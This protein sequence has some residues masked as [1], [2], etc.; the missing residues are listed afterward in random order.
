MVEIALLC[1]AYILGLLLPSPG[2]TLLLC[3]GLLVVALLRSPYCRSLPLPLSWRYSPTWGWWVLAALV[4]SMAAL[5]FFVRLPTPSLQDVSRL[6]PASATSVPV[7]ITGKIEQRPALTRRG[8][9]QVWLQAQQATLEQTP[10]QTV[11]GHLYVTLPR[12][13]AKQLYPNQIVRILGQLYRPQ[14]STRPHGFD[15]EAFLAREGVF[16][17]L[18]GTQVR[19]IAPGS[20]WGGW[21][22][23][24]RIVAAL[25]QGA[26]KRTGALLSALVLG[27]DAADIAYDLKDSF[28]QSGLAHALAA[29]GFQVSLILSA[30]LALTQSFSPSKQVAIGFGALLGYGLLSGAEP[31][32]VRAILMG[33]ASLMAL[34]LKRQIRPVLLLLAIATLM[35]LWNPLWI[36]D[37]GFLLSMLATLGL[38]VTVPPLMGYLEWLPPTIASLVAVPL[39]ANLWTLPLQLYVFGVLP[40]YSLIA[41][42]LT[43]GLLS[44][45]TIGGF[46]ASC[47]ALIWPT[48]GSGFAWLLQ[49]PTQLLMGIVSSIAQLPGHALAIGT[50]SLWQLLTLYGCLGV[51]WI[52]GRRQW[53]LMTAVGL[54]MIL[55]PLW[56]VQTQRFL[57]TVFDRTQVPQMVIAH[58]KGTV[59]LNSGNPNAVTQSL[60]PF[61]HQEGINRIDW[62]I[63][64][65]SDASRQSGW[66]AL[67]RRMP[68]TTLS[69]CIPQATEIA[70][71][72]DPRP[73]REV[74]LNRQDR[75]SLGPL[76]MVVWRAQPAILELQINSQRWLLVDGSNEA[77][78][79]AW[80]A[81]TQLPPVQ[82]LWWTGDTLSTAIAK[83]LQPQV[84]L[85][86]GHLE[87]QTVAEFQRIVPRVLWTERDGTVQWTPKQQFSVTVNPGDRPSH[88]M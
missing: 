73:Q 20:Q 55:V 56:Q 79:S 59:L 16:A 58:P 86:S 65:V 63:A 30:V 74:V 82:V 12:K 42:I 51:V 39:A 38:I 2:G 77:D 36:A 32:I 80:L 35:L 48:L 44:A 1:C 15:F 3:G 81:T 78:F 62:A 23:R 41:N 67:L 31:S 64:T 11:A 46:I 17:G 54:L 85:L 47:S 60:V 69:R 27:K 72:S 70:P 18:R 68:I 13:A 5:Y 52:W 26:G 14:P 29:S 9:V 6:I 8:S 45:L 49:W 37:L 33:S 84:L 76:Q 7:E 40:L 57:V 25:E 34:G 50:L 75:V 71:S 88:S 83:Q 19:V 10:P 24:A 43:A 22:I 61:L 21:A 66:P 4:S 28:I 87:E 53:K